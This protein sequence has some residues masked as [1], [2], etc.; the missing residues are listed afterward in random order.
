M[1]IIN[2]SEM[3]NK[4]TYGVLC[5]SIP[6][7]SDII[8]GQTVYL[9]LMLTADLKVLEDIQS[10]SIESDPNLIVEK[11]IV[12]WKI[13]EDKTKG[14]TVFELD[15]N[16]K[17]PPKTLI[18]YTVRAFSG[19]GAIVQEVAPLKVTY[20]SKKISSDRSILLN[21]NKEYMVT[22]I[23]DNSIDKPS[24]KYAVICSTIIDDNGDALKNVA[25]T[26]SSA[27]QEKLRLVNFSTDEESPRP[28]N[29]QSYNT[30]FNFITV[31]SDSKGKIK[32]RIYPKQ[33]I[34][35]RLDLTTTILN[36]TGANLVY[37]LYVITYP[38]K[39]SYALGLPS[40]QEMDEGNKIKQDLTSSSMNFHVQIQDYHPAYPTDGILFFIKRE[41]N[42]T[43]ELLEPI[44]LAGKTSELS[45]KIFKFPYNK[46]PLN[47]QVD[48]FY[49]MSPREGD[50]KQSYPISVTYL[51]GE[52]KN[53]KEKIY[54]QYDKVRV[55]GSAVDL[56]IDLSSND[57]LVEEHSSVHSDTISFQKD[58]G[59][60][61]INDAVGL[62]VIVPASND[63]KNKS[64]PKVGQSGGV[65]LYYIS[66][67]RNNQKVYKFKLEKDIG[68]IVQ[69]PY[70][71][72]SRATNYNGEDGELFFD[73]YIDEGNGTKTYSHI[74]VAGIGTET[75]RGDDNLEG[76]SP[77]A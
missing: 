11:C 40:I 13:S 57:Y 53:P 12:E 18:N 67:T 38:Q 22:P 34:Q 36:V 39:D 29:T 46:L 41:S 52:E 30:D 50:A 31:Y 4:C 76:C 74:F 62:Y 33:Q 2:E 72:L 44:Y 66:D 5:A 48:F 10:I 19:S 45:N 51:G 27:H 37:T 15:V 56:P 25:V 65:N 77:D 42:D 61:N 75:N 21:S 71:A 60:K 8:I 20:T 47:E 28:I 1:N 3:L 59:H 7:G 64:L 6:D 69:I 49:V 16:S 55:Y 14:S 23:T 32:F 70:C 9:E 17:I 54:R 68:N 26:I 24:S 63:P 73:Y 43:P 58:Y 35:V